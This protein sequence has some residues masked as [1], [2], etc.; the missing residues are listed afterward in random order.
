MLKNALR[1]VVWTLVWAPSSTHDTLALRI[2]L[3][4]AVERGA[5]VRGYAY[6]VARTTVALCEC[7]YF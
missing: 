5:L 2:S 7:T 6:G 1:V 3:T 4:P